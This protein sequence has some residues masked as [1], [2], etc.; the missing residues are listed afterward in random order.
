MKLRDAS[1]IL[2]PSSRSGR[3]ELI[4]CINYVLKLVKLI[5][6]ELIK[7]RNIYRT[8]APLQYTNCIFKHDIWSERLLITF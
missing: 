1:R 6:L 8:R 5:F 2:P 4:L 7:Q 3:C